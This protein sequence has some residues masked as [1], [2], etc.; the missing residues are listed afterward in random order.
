MSRQDDER[1]EELKRQRQ[2]EMEEERQQRIRVDDRRRHDE[3]VRFVQREISRELRGK[4]HSVSEENLR[5]IKKQAIER[6]ER[7]P[8]AVD[9]VLERQAERRRDA[10]TVARTTV[11][12]EAATDL[13]NERRYGFQA[14]EQ[15]QQRQGGGRER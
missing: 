7:N 9:Q 4:G 14:Q 13:R 1:E 2:R 5:Q 8:S 15:K 11:L 3:A 6:F 10:Q 12:P